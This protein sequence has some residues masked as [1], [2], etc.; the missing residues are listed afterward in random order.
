MNTRSKVSHLARFC[1]ATTAGLF[2]MSMAHAE[3]WPN[4]KIGLLTDMSGPF[5]QFSGEGSVVAAQMAIDD[6]LAKECK[7]MKVQ[8][9]TADHQ[10]KTDI[11]LTKAR[12]WADV[13][14]VDAYADMVNSAVSLAMENLAVQKKKIALFVGG[15]LSITN[16][17][18]Q[19][20]YAVQWMWDTYSQTA[21]AIKGLAKPKQSW[22]FVTVDYAYGKVASS[23]ARKQLD[24]I[25]AHVVGESKHPLN[26]IDMS[27]QII[28]AQQSSADVV[29]FINSGADA[30]NAVK[31]ASEFKL[32]AK[33]ELAAFFPTVYEIK[34]IGLEQ[35][36]GLQFPESFYWDFDDGTRRFS[37]RFME[38]YKKGPPS[39]THA[40][41]YSSVYHY[42]KSVAAAKSTDPAAVM[43]EMH[44]LP[45]N[46]DVVRNA[47]LRADGRMIHDYYYVK[48]KSP[49]ESRSPWDLYTIQKVLP[50]DQ[51]F[52][53]ASQSVCPVLKNA[54]ASH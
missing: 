13:D 42:L 39:L 8:L 16:E 14:H 9:L 23:E 36:Q 22:Y 11:A 30:A 46:D 54:A 25:G 27:S 3:T 15:P 41:V 20:D 6:C 33:K 49:K 28:A 29:G 37:K 19:P 4:V 52:L 53:P 32:G 48:V 18:C 40:G 5:S 2:A 47:T 43:R 17:N 12:E 31:T 50:G 34:G 1:V 10:N 7:G 45:I 38:I 51:V 21:A 24:A 35:A 44:K 26:S